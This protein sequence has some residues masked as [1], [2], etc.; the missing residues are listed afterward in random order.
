[1]IYL[2]SPYSHPD[3]AVREARFHAACRAAAE[4]MRD[5]DD[6]TV[7]RDSTIQ[8]KAYVGLSRGHD[9]LTITHNTVEG[10]AY[11]NGGSGRED[12]LVAADNVFA[13]FSIKYFEI[14]AA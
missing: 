12:R 10:K 11:L 3:V 7:V 4:F 1:M 14:F 5:G 2:A 8:T 6:Q 13:D 9:G